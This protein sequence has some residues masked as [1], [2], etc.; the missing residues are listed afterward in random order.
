MRRYQQTGSR[1]S[2]EGRDILSHSVYKLAEYFPLQRIGGWKSKSCERSLMLA[3]R[4]DLIVSK[5]MNTSLVKIA[6]QRENLNL[7]LSA[8]RQASLR[9]V[10][11]DDFRAVARLT[12][13]AAR[14]NQSLADNEIGI[15]SAR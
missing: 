6:R 2:C 8:I 13:E 4:G 12:L 3:G 14:V 10:R 7:E 15:E 5:P 1:L 11:H 9:A